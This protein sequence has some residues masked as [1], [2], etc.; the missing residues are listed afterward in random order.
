MITY[1]FKG[2][3][4]KTNEWVYGNLIQT[5]SKIGKPAVYIFEFPVFIPAI[6]LPVDE[7][8][9]VDP[10]TITCEISEKS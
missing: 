7:F 4:V 3:S 2:K 1:K 6:S 9:E 10:D 8:H 5:E